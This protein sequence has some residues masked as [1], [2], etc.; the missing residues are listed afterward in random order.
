MD[1]RVVVATNQRLRGLVS[2]GR[3]RADLYY[4]LAGV[5]LQVPPLRGR[6]GDI[7]ELAEY[8][9]ARHRGLRRLA[10]SE[11]AAEALLT[12]DWPGNVRELQRVVERA[13]ALSTETWWRCRTCRRS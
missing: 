3:F 7:V 13:L 8:F 9:L 5:E 11:S 2:A 12:Y 6:R 10:L 1:I 4:R